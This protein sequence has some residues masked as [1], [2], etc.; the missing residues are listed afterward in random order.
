VVLWYID[1]R[2]DFDPK[3]NLNQKTNSN[4]NPLNRIEL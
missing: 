1:A 2:L 3:P 4:P